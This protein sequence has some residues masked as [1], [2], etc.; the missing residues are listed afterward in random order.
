MP[1]IIRKIPQGSQIGKFCFLKQLQKGPDTEV[2][3]RVDQLE[4][5]CQLRPTFCAYSSQDSELGPVKWTL[6]Y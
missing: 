4:R 3:L 1:R 2:S 6:S 5:L